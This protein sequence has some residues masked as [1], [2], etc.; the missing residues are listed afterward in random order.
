VLGLLYYLFSFHRDEPVVLK[1][2]GSGPVVSILLNCKD[3]GA[4][5]DVAAGRSERY[6]V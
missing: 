4:W 5:S 3:N 1:S 2:K 6:G